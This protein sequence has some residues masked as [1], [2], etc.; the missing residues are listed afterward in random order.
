MK[1]K[2]T[3]KQFANLC[4]VEK[5]TLFYY[6]EI[7][8]LKPIEITESGYRL[9]ATEQFDTMSMIKAL[10]SV[11]MSLGDI[12]ALMNQLDISECKVVLNNQIGLLKEKQEELRSAEQIL[13][14]TM[15]QLDQYLEI[16]CNQ[17]Y[18][19]DTPDIYLITG[20]MPER[21]TKHIN[22][23]T[24]GHHIG[25]IMQEADAT[26]PWLVFKKATARKNANAVKPAGA[27]ASIYQSVPNGKI[28]EAILSFMDLLSSK[29]IGT[30]G[31]MYLD[32][33]ASDFIR[34]PNEEYIFK[35]SIKCKS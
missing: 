5:R 25:I 26:V 1:D 18:I 33:L 21:T 19:D 32:D 29:L 4:K 24:I 11:G 3:T 30:E 20:E 15:E 2:L 16:G 6:D 9:Y 22:Y 13:S 8:L 17:F 27:Y 34:F 10:Q 23:I 12:K 31:P 35:L 7:D 28:S 14:Q